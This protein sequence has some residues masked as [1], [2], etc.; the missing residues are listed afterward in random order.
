MP[1]QGAPRKSNERVRESTNENEISDLTQMNGFSCLLLFL[2]S[3]YIYASS[4]FTFISPLNGLNACSLLKKGVERG[5]SWG[6]GS[7]GRPLT[8][9]GR[10][11]PRSSLPLPT[12]SSFMKNK[13]RF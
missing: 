3:I 11:A 4:Q 5:K 12:P 1:P 9:F 13:N 7:G 10:R 2:L 8:A 6:S